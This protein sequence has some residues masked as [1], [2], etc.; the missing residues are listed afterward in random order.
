MSASGAPNDVPNCHLDKTNMDDSSMHK[1]NQVY[2]ALDS[3]AMTRRFISNAQ[4]TASM[5]KM[6]YRKESLVL[7]GTTFYSLHV[8]QL[9]DV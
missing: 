8:S 2:P 1:G 5:Q 9:T 4:K 3:E 7:I 6:D